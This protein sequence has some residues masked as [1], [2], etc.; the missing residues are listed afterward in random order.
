MKF[1]ERYRRAH[2]MARAFADCG[3]C[4]LKRAGTVGIQVG[5]KLVTPSM[6]MAALVAPR[7]A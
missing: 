3:E 5:L 6:A 7:G 4:L 2:A 1:R